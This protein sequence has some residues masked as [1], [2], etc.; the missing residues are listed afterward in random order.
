MES[1]NKQLTEQALCALL[2]SRDAA[3]LQKAFAYL[4]RHPEAK[5]KMEQRYLAFIRLR[6]KDE[7]ATLEQLEAA[8]LSEKEESVFTSRYNLGR[9]F[10]SFGMMDDQG[11]RLIVDFIGA[12]VKGRIDVDGYLEQVKTAPNRDKMVPHVEGERT[13]LK[14]ALAQE[15]D[16]YDEGWYGKVVRKLNE[17]SL[18]RVMFDHTSFESAN[19]S[20]VLREFILFVGL[21]AYQLYFDI[22][23]STA[24]D[25]TEVFWTIPRIPTTAWGDTSPRFPASPLS[26]GRKA[27]YREGDDGKWLWHASHPD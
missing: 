23:Q 15:A 7:A 25:L 27:R 20:P 24:P 6:L 17:L 2:E 18:D 5:A 3:Q 8:A 16:M 9:D 13:R 14:N 19:E 1:E 12:F 26:F 22:F 4:A 10:L 11:A 21:K